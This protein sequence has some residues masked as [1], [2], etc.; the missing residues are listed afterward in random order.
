MHIFKEG[1]SVMF[2]LMIVPVDK[3]KAFIKCKI[4]TAASLRTLFL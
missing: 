4:T 1:F 2:Y 3:G